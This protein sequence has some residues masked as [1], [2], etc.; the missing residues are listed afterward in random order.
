MIMRLD[1]TGTRL[2]R[3]NQQGVLSVSRRHPEQVLWQLHHPAGITAVAWSWD[4]AYLASGDV[5]GMIQVWEAQTGV[6]VKSSQGHH[7]EVVQLAWS[8]TTY[9]LTSTALRESVLRIWDYTPLLDA[10]QRTRSA[11]PEASRP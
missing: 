7:G 6:L 2:A 10:R 1:P 4:S 8:P 5:T 11:G 9:Q 3:G